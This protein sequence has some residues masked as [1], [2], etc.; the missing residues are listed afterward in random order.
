MPDAVTDGYDAVYAAWHS[1]PTFHAI[2]ARHTVDDRYP[3][4]FEHISFVTFD[5]LVVITAALDRGPQNLLDIAC[6][7]GGPG[8]WVA[9]Q[10]DARLVGVDLSRVGLRVAAWRAA[11]SAADRAS[12][13][14]ADVTALPLASGCGGSAM[15]VDALQYVRDKQRAFAEVYRVLQT[16]GR[17][18]FTAFELEPER[19]AGIPVLGDDPVEDYRPVLEGVGF[20]VERYDETLE[21]HE[22]LHDAYRAVLAAEAQLLTEMGERAFR[23]LHG[24]MA[25]TMAVEPYRR[26]VLV[27]C[28]K[29]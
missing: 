3:A 4:G 8:L 9:G 16:G 19:V 13:A 21:W 28:S 18:V 7:A 15:S 10:L 23:A 20:H 26:R 24:E 6:G 29:P 1:S 12:F 14:A 17:L 25:L 5:E 2:W 22:R 11:E 27:V